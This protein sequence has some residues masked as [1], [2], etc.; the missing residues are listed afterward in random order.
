MSS[1]E[2][3]DAH[4]STDS[5]LARAPEIDEPTGVDTALDSRY[6]L[7]GP[8]DATRSVP[9][10]DAW[11]RMQYPVPGGDAAGGDLEPGTIGSGSNYQAVQRPDGSGV[12]QSPAGTATYA[13]RLPDGTVLRNTDRGP[14]SP[15]SYAGLDTLARE[16]IELP[17]VFVGHVATMQTDLDNSDEATTR[18]GV[19]WDFEEDTFIE[20][21]AF[22]REVVEADVLD[23]PEEEGVL[24]THES[25]VQLY[26]GWDS[27]AADT[28]GVFG[29]VPFD[30]AAGTR[31]P[32]A[33]DALDLLKP[34]D[35]LTRGED[36]P[37]QGEWFLIPSDTGNG[38]SGTV[39]KPGVGARPYGASPLE[40]HVP[41]D[42]ATAVEDRVFLERVS[43]RFDELPESVETPQDVFEWLA[44]EGAESNLY[45]AA[46][47][48][49]EG[50][51][52]RGTLRHRDH[53]HRVENVGDEWHRAE[54]HEFD[55]ITTD[56]DW[57]GV[58]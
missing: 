30:G 45:A 58:D 52:V 40:N 5:Q 18:P 51:Y 6:E 23:H 20:G 4:A 10:V 49:A 9:I 22:L 55:V 41:R 33:R 44:N 19:Q 13:V 25:G 28:D 56:G 31:V 53:D 36:V 34:Q 16:Y 47:E 54:T 7:V 39:Q 57:I 3:S 35:V 43:E 37:R 27:T 2:Y 15:W 21:D 29:F 26:V 12:F 11:L 24:L 42:W 38:P 14:N 17:F 1:T 50:I 48:L 8:I 32:S 46:R